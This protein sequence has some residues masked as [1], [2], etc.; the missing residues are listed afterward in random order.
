M[1]PLGSYMC[2]SETGKVRFTSLQSTKKHVIRSVKKLTDLLHNSLVRKR[3]R[4]AS[5]YQLN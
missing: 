2:K 5:R 3:L 4:L 1:V